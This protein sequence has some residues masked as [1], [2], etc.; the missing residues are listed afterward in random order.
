[1]T[2]GRPPWAGSDRRIV[3]HPVP[4]ATGPR[5][6][7][8]PRVVVVGGGIAGLSAATVLAERGVGVVLVEREP[9]LGGRVG[10]WPDQLGDGSTVTMS[11]GFH[12]F[13]RQ[14]YNLRRL[15]ARTDPAL[16]RLTPVADYPLMDPEGRTDTFRG[17]PRRPPWNALAFAVKSPT[18][19]VPDLL[20]L[21]ARAALPL[22]TVRV[23]RIYEQLDGT[24]AEEL[25]DAINFPPAARHLA[26]EVFSRSF[27]ASPKEL[28]AAEL[29]VMFHLYFLGSSEGLLFDVPTDTFAISLWDPLGGHLAEL[30]VDV[31]TGTSVHTVEP[32]GERKYRVHTGDGAVDADGVVLA[33]DPRALRDVVQAS[34][35]LGDPGWRENVARLRTAPP[36][37]VHRLWLDRPLAPHRP[38]FLGTGGWG[39][40]DNISV[41]DRYESEALHWALERRGA[42]V[43][44]HAYAAAAPGAD[45]DAVVPALSRE[46]ERQLHLI[47]PESE[48]AEVVDSR[49]LWREDC[50]LFAPGSFAE[51]PTVR[52]PDDGLVLAGDGIRIDLPV[53]LME[54]AATTGTHAANLLLAGFGLPGQELFT[55]P[56]YGRLN[57]L[58]WFSRPRSEKE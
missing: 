23:P 18:F 12:A 35:E 8:Q 53:A 3:R 57:P 6:A 11:R 58:H 32:G 42:V 14:Y 16:E 26:F 19:S 52:T 24:T 22:A 47:Y 28:S 50:P 34:P 33:T 27:F 46:L 54:R 41:L 30:G 55:V 51:R 37:L 48:A 38:S 4:A 13:F 43:E 20:R 2:G 36:F 7:R 56:D 44:L 31:R 10:A 45:R 9:Y 1:M 49:S 25:L 29:A 21:N 15:L 39:P 17:I 5:G 40:L